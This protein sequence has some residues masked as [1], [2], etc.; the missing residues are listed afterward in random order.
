MG[1]TDLKMQISRLVSQVKRQD[2]SVAS[3]RAAC[4]RAQGKKLKSLESL[5]GRGV[6]EKS[7]EHSEGT[8][9]VFKH[10]RKDTPLQQ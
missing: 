1:E 7:Q 6:A 5:K 2:G 3:S 9:T 10:S 4:V 8:V